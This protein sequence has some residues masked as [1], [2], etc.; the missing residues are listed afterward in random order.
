MYAVSGGHDD[1][2]RLPPG[3]RCRRR[4]RSARG[5]TALSYAALKERLRRAPAPREGRRRNAKNLNGAT[6]LVIAASHG[7]VKTAAALVA[8]GADLNAAARTGRRPS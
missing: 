2:A 8:S 7:S 3:A 4:P 5:D 1:I 6:P